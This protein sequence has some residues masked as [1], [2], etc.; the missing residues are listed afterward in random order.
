MP[1][2]LSTESWFAMDDDE[3]EE[4]SEAEEEEEEEEEPKAKNKSGNNRGMYDH[5]KE[6]DDFDAPR[7]LAHL[8]ELNFK[9]NVG[10][11]ARPTPTRKNSTFAFLR[12]TS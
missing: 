8:K 2:R 6:A 5:K 9:V 12:R 3:S 4:S 7:P 11:K 1:R 10:L